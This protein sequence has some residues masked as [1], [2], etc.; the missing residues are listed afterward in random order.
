MVK[1]V[2]HG[3]WFVREQFPVSYI[4]INYTQIRKLNNRNTAA[5]IT[6]K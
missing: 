1:T 4:S 5:N 2:S 3:V 6:L